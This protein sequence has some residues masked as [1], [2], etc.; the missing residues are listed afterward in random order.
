MVVLKQPQYAKLLIRDNIFPEGYF[1]KPH[2]RVKLKE[3]SEIISFDYDIPIVDR[4]NIVIH[5]TQFTGMYE[6]ETNNVYSFKNEDKILIC[7]ND[8]EYYEYYL[9][10]GTT[11]NKVVFLDFSRSYNEISNGIKCIFLKNTNIPDYAQYCSDGTGKYLWRE[12]IKD[13]ELLQ[14]SDIYDR[15]Y[16]NG[17]VYINSNINFYL[18]RQDPYGIYGVKYDDANSGEVSN[19]IINGVNVELPDIDYKIQENYSICE[20]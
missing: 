13:T 4:D 7:Y 8:G 6:F 5:E 15:T 10:D 1:Y 12:I 14:T 17:A 11:G 18:R 2:Y 3:F 16:G 9:H 19:F 20:I